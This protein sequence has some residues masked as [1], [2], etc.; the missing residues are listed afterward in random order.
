RGLVASSSIAGT[1]TRKPRAA[2][3]IFFFPSSVNGRR[4]S[5]DSKS[6]RS[7]AMAWRIKRRFIEVPSAAQRYRDRPPQPRGTPRLRLRRKYRL[8]AQAQLVERL[9]LQDPIGEV[10]Q[11]VERIDRL[12]PLPNL[13]RDLSEPLSEKANQ[14]SAETLRTFAE[15]LLEP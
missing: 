10:A 3:C 14:G 2:R 6:E 15:S 12:D 1:A 9:H 5:L 13:G 11:L 8:A 7:A 4:S